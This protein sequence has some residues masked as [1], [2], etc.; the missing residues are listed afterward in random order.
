MS[1]A[2]RARGPDAAEAAPKGRHPQAHPDSNQV[3]QHGSAPGGWAHDPRLCATCCE[4][5]IWDPQLRDVLELRA[6]LGGHRRIVDMQEV[7]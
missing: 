4:S 1:P 5:T 2:H 6:W 3:G 7:A